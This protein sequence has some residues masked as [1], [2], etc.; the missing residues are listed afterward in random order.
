M[1]VQLLSPVGIIIPASTRKH[2]HA[3]GGK[4]TG[5]RMIFLITIFVDSRILSTDNVCRTPLN[6]LPFPVVDL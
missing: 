5:V 6:E 4:Y 1:Y 2:I 3:L